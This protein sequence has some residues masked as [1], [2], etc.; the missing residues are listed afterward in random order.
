V[1]AILPVHL[2]GEEPT[3]SRRRPR[4][5]PYKPTPADLA[6]LA[7]TAEL[8]AGVEERMAYIR[9]RFPEV[10]TFGHGFGTRL[11]EPR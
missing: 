10:W 1:E 4:R 3:M 6:R 2:K 8:R 5:S 11:R 9:E 7:R